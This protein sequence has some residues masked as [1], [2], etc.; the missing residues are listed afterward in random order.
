MSSSYK[1]KI[2]DYINNVLNK[3]R[4][5]F[6][7]VATC[8]FAAPELAK[9]KLMVVMMHEE[10]KGIKDILE[11]FAAS[12]CDSALI[13]LPHE[14]PAENTKPFQ[15]F[16]NAILKRLGLK[17]YK[18]ICFNPNDEVEVQGYN[19]RSEAPYFMINVAHK[20]ALNDAH[21]SLRKTKY[22]D[23]LNKEYREFL[24]I[25]EKDKK[26]R[27]GKKKKRTEGSKGKT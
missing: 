25:N 26:T 5:E 14:L 7:D 8:P 13:A 19:P 20:K 3:K 24:K 1:Q 9:D 10:D 11:D 2:A 22:Y 18:C 15:I 17:D 27:S 6:N 4:P 16:V 12:D 23:N 21:K